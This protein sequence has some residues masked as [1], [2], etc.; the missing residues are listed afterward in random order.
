MKAQAAL[1]TGRD[2]RQGLEE[3]CSRLTIV[4]SEP[5]DLALLFATSEY[6]AEYPELLAEVRRRTGARV[7]IGCSG[8]G[9][10]GPAREVENEPA[11]ALQ[12][13]SLPGAL[14]R[15]AR[16]APEDLEGEESRSRWLRVNSGGDAPKAWLL[17]LDPYTIESEAALR[18]LSE[19][20]PGLPIVGGLASGYP[21]RSRTH[22]FLDGEAFDEGG[23]ALAIGGAYRVQTV[24]SQGCAPIGETW[25]ITGAHSNLIDTIGMRP[26]LEVLMDTFRGL[27]PDVQER[28]RRNLLVGLAMDEYRDEFR[29]GD[30]LI[31]NLLGVD[32]ESGAIAIGAYPRVGQT[33]QFQLRDPSAADEDLTELLTRVRGEL[34]DEKP[35]GALL[36]SCNGRGAGL[37]GAPDHDAR[38]MAEILGPV[39]VAGF[40]CNGEIGPVGGKNFLHGFTA[41]VALILPD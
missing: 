38:A 27:A 4:G 1:A 31:R 22:V 12:V 10:I 35:I 14:L 21:A 7:L 25:T 33:V 6:E 23:A 32:Q 16:L 30:F 5:I 26:A 24:V 11:L 28:A 36:C 2:W 19:A 40:F 34:G 18:F 20:N 17:F 41:S 39:P 15:P 3:A 13:F 8:Q 9:I 29:R 37:F